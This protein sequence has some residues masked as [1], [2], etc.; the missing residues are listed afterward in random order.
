MLENGKQLKPKEMR[1]K[2]CN[3]NDRTK[4]NK[5]KKEYVNEIKLD[6]WK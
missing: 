3:R 4:N 5:S 1:R 6:Y 2:S